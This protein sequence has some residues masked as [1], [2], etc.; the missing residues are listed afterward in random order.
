M[1]LGWNHLWV[2]RRGSCSLLHCPLHHGW[3]HR[4]AFQV[5]MRHLETVAQGWACSSA[6]QNPPKLGKGWKQQAQYQTWVRR[7]AGRE[8]APRKTWRE[9]SWTR[10]EFQTER[11]VP[12]RMG[13]AQGKVVSWQ[14]QP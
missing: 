4:S 10:P 6:R 7:A 2:P 3:K 11:Q 5:W 8:Q 1:G 9:Q 12:Q 13:Q 14:G